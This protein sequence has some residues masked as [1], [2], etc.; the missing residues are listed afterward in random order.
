M[1][2]IILCIDDDPNILA[3][4]ERTLRRRFTLETAEGG[5]EGLEKIRQK[6][7]YAVVVAD[8]MMPGLNGIETLAQIRKLSPDTVR[9]MLT[10]N[11][12]QQTA[13]DAVNQGN[14]FRFLTKP[15][16]PEA[17][18]LALEAGLEQY[19]LITAERE[20]LEKTLSG[21]IKMLT[22]ILSLVEPQI[23]GR[24][25]MMRDYV[26]TLA[27]VLN[28]TQIWELEVAAMLCQI[29]Y[30]TIP[31]TIIQKERARL[32]LSP[33]EQQALIRI[34]EIGSKL[35][36]H[37]PRLESVSRIVLYQNKNYDG[38]GFP[39]NSVSGEDIPMGARI[40]RVLAD[41]IQA[42]IGGVRKTEALEKMRARP[43][44][45][46]PK[47]MEAAF[48]SLV[49]DPRL[50][51]SGHAVKVKELQVGQML[52]SPVET[53]DGVL[54]LPAGTEVSPMLLAKLN[55]FAELTGVKEPVYV[56]K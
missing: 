49:Q 54:I 35:L 43:G 8:M 48:A 13:I 18:A 38:S 50:K 37:V 14:I 28:I 2:E 53:L 27:P 15:C 46:D 22:E 23:F 36:A 52:L 1:S 24:S 16:P 41:F 32:T 40:L 12:D 55:N 11:A 47:V 31:V 19:R 6:G 56:S 25:Q 4:Y 33:V 51:M 20:L 21:S 39:Q 9:I 17:L 45:Y 7:S 44:A 34:P 26:R 3:A 10:G 29:G 5:A 42:E 30:V